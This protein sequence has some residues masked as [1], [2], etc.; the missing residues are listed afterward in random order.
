MSLFKN[1]SSQKF[2]VLLLLLGSTFFLSCSSEETIAEEELPTIQTGMI[3]ATINVNGVNRSYIL[4][5]PSTYTAESSMPLVFNFHGL[6][7]N[8]F[9]QMVYGDFR[10]LAEEHG[11]I[12]AHPNGTTFLGF[13]HWNVGGFTAGS[14][15]DDVGFTEALLAEIQSDYNIDNNRI[16]ATG[17]SNGGYMAFLLGCQMNDTFAAIAS[18]T[19][20]M[21]IDTYDECIPNA[22]MPV[23]QIHGTADETVS[24]EGTET[25]NK[26][27]PDVLSYWVGVNNCNPTPS[28]TRV[29][30][31]N[32][33]DDDFVDH[34]VYS[35][36]DNGTVVEHY[37]INNGTHSW[38]GTSVGVANRTINASNLV[39]E[40]FS[41]YN[42]SGLIQ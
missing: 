24:Y 20:T 35:G 2:L 9:E 10:P 12:I 11:F 15:A 23:L 25:W 32:P 40:F 21:T 29:P 41:R 31:L 3:N 6:G 33:N 14:P 37:K 34:Y 18:V 17:M 39:W 7:S 30:D 28:I 16:Y 13:T 38:P 5:V 8:A 26:S 36:G 22:P 1:H 4:Y 42:K 27:I 19:G